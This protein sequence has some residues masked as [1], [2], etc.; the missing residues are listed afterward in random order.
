M[1][2]PLTLNHL[3]VQFLLQLQATAL[4]INGKHVFITRFIKPQ[5]APPG[6]PS[7]ENNLQMMVY[8]L[9][10][11][12]IYLWSI[13]YHAQEHLAHFV[14]LIPFLPDAIVFSENYNIWTTS[15]VSTIKCF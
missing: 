7:V 5:K 2:L 15:D 14:S 4:D 8:F 12:I 13:K 9:D 3:N 10:L 11:V 6:V 1:W